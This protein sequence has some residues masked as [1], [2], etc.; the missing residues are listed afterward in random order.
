MRAADSVSAAARSRRLRSRR[1]TRAIV[2]G[3]LDICGRGGSRVLDGREQVVEVVRDAAREQADRFHLLRPPPPPPPLGPSAP[4][5]P[6][7]PPRP[8]SPRLSKWTK[9]LRGA[10]AVPA[11]LFAR[12]LGGSSALGFS[13]PPAPP[14]GLSPLRGPP[15]ALPPPPPLSP[16]SSHSCL[17][18]GT[19][20]RRIARSSR[21]AP[22]RPSRRTGAPARSERDSPLRVEQHE[23]VA[24]ALARER[25]LG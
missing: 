9:P 19:T 13:G 18:L 8:P 5:P 10:R 14:L 22:D 2:R 21:R 4:V 6:T 12:V 1:R 11:S 25:Q 20:P 7:P 16:S 15:R 24:Q 3:A 17:G 23:R